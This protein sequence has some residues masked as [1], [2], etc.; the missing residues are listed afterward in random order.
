MEDRMSAVVDEG[1]QG[2]VCQRQE[3]MEVGKGDVRN[4]D[5]HRRPLK[6]APL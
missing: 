4:Q 1:M 3:L 2:S 6:M 5:E